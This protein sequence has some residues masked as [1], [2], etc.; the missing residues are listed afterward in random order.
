MAIYALKD[1]SVGSL[2][3]IGRWNPKK[4]KSIEDVL[5]LEIAAAA[6]SATSVGLSLVGYGLQ[7]EVR[8]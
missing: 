2:Y 6:S 1:A 3:R 5:L 7:P 4:L 8:R